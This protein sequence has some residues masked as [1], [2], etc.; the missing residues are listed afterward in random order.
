MRSVQDIW[1]DELIEKATKQ[2]QEENEDLRKQLGKAICKIIGLERE[3][4]IAEKALLG[5]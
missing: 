2:L 5:I 4:V 3:I 1:I